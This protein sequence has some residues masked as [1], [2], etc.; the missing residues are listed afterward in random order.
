MSKGMKEAPFSVGRLVLFSSKGSTEEPV[1]QGSGR[2]WSLSR[3]S[4]SRTLLLEA[5]S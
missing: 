3:H 5:G 4:C 2:D 1:G